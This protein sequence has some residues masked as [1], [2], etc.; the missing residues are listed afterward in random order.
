MITEGYSVISRNHI[1]IS[2]YSTCLR[3]HHRFY[4]LYFQGRFWPSDPL[5]QTLSISLSTRIKPHRYAYAVA[6]VRYEWFNGRTDDRF[7]GYIIQDWQDRPHISTVQVMLSQLRSY[8]IRKTW[9][10]TTHP[11]PHAAILN[12]MQAV[13]YSRTFPDH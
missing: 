8:N 3:V 7:Q 13:L 11:H 12:C 10:T 5:R 4:H 6:T 9:T 1:G 2:I